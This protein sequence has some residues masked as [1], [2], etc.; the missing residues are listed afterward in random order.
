MNFRFP[1]RWAAVEVGVVNHGEETIFLSAN[2][3]VSLL[4]DSYVVRFVS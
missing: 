4:I 3:V 2:G 1:H